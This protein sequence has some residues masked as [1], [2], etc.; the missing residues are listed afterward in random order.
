VTQW[1]TDAIYVA[2]WLQIHESIDPRCEPLTPVM[3]P[4]SWS[5]PCVTVLWR[6]AQQRDM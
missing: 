3:W 2:C 5:D 4:S 1:S 6:C